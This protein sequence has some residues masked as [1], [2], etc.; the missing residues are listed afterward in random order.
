MC[1]DAHDLFPGLKD[2]KPR[3]FAAFAVL[4]LASSCSDAVAPA[5]PTPLS[6][7]QQRW[8]QQDLHTYAYTL[9]R[10][11]FCGNVDPLY[12][13]VVRDTVVGVLDLETGNWVDIEL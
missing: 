3:F 10:S 12:D 6:E 11:C 8:R 5:A 13:A 4:M 1:C 9:Q 7:A 2:M